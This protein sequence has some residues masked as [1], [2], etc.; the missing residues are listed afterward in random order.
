M[1]G[2]RMNVLYG[3]GIGFSQLG[4]YGALCLEMGWHLQFLIDAKDIPALGRH[5][6]R[7]NML[8]S[9]L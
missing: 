6:R 8:C 7:S 1:V 2:L 9:A 5:G 3:G 4:D